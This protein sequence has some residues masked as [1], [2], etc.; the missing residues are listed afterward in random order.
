MKKLN[1]HLCNVDEVGGDERG[2]SK[3]KVYKGCKR[4][5]SW[6][7]TDLLGGDHNP[8]HCTLM[9]VSLARGLLANAVYL[10][11]SSPGAINPRMCERLY[12][13]IPGSWAVRRSDSGSMTKDLFQDWAQYFVKSMRGMGYGKEFKKPLILLIDGHSSRWTY[14]GLKTL[15]D[16]GIF[17]FFIAS[18]TSAWH[19]PN[20]VGLNISYKSRF[21]KAV[22]R[23]LLANPYDI[24]DRV[25]F[26]K[27]CAEAI[28]EVRIDLAAE[29]AKYEAKQ[30][31]WVK[32]GSPVALKPKGK[33]G[34]VV[35]R[36][37]LR[38]GWWPLKKNSILW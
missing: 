6:R 30:K 35:T 26:N 12:E 13:H 31:A 16:A 28:A 18:H 37:Y 8:F 14:Q 11:H 2:Q 27:C 38:T 17:P 21:A 5:T 9:L 32:C 7:T 22:K 25:S 34:N 10:I 20:D 24:F 29:L 19:Q 3:R 15:M 33:P 4:N 23:W 36:M 1:E